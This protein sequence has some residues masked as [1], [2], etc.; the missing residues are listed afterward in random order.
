MPSNMNSVNLEP[1]ILDSTLYTVTWQN[2]DGTILE[3]DY[4]FS[5]E[6]PV[7]DGINPTKPGDST[8]TY[9]FDGWSPAVTTVTQNVIYT[10]QYSSSYVNYTIT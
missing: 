7:Y 2:Y 6:T 1:T 8:Y 10:A 3:T 9:T 4:Y 5:G